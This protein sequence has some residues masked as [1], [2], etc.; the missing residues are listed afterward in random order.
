MGDLPVPCLVPGCVRAVSATHSAAN[1]AID[2][3]PLGHYRI[4][5][6][7]PVMIRFQTLRQVRTRKFHNRLHF[8]AFLGANIREKGRSVWGSSWKRHH[9]GN[10]PNNATQNLHS[11]SL[12]SAFKFWMLFLNTLQLPIG[13][14]GF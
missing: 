6:F 10:T 3:E 1:T 7:I 9:R 14:T 12:S 11:T 4:A 8:E 5:V 2:Q 13:G